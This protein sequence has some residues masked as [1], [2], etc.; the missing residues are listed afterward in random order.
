MIK[1]IDKDKVIELHY[2]E[3]IW[4]RDYVFAITLTTYPEEAISYLFKRKHCDVEIGDE[5]FGDVTFSS[6]DEEVARLS[7][8]YGW[9]DDIVNRIDK[10]EPLRAT[11][12][13]KANWY[14]KKGNL[15]WSS[16]FAKN[17]TH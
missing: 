12:V 5:V 3:F 15:H 17:S 16:Y 1:L 6:D 11:F 10:S 7:E 4:K 2:G 13:A 8:L 9:V 14:V